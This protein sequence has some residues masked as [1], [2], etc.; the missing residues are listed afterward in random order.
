MVTLFLFRP[1]HKNWTLVCEMKE[2]L[3]PFQVIYAF[4]NS[5]YLKCR[6]F[7]FKK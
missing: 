1:D 3:L 2:W 7:P 5:A 6:H 4:V